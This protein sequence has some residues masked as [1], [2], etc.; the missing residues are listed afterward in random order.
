[1]NNLIYPD[2]RTHLEVQRIV[3]DEFKE[4]FDWLVENNNLSI[5]INEG[6]PALC[7]GMLWRMKPI[8]T[9]DVSHVL[10]RDADAITTYKE[11]QAVQVWIESGFYFHAINDNP[12][13]GGLM[14]GL[15][16]FE[17]SSFKSITGLN[18]FDE[19]VSGYS[20]SERG[21]DQHLLNAF[22]S[23][24]NFKLGLLCHLFSGAGCGTAPAAPNLPDLPLVEKKYLESNLVARHIGSAGVV[25]LELLRFF[26]RHDLY[27]WKFVVI[28][29]QYKELFPWN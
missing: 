1:M 7:E 28:E 16:G 13:H 19:M 14:G 5:S 3:Y 27:N 6:Y 26:K 22:L 29:K 23:N 21:S 10:C 17:T 25:E 24:I 9:Q 11:A 4:L 2:C 15:T 20:L 18:S 12:S 8:W